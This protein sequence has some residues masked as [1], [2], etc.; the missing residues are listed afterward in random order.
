MKDLKLIALDVVDLGVLSAHL[1]DAVMLVGDMVYQPKQKRF[2]AI[3]NRFDW[4][5]ALGVTLEADRK[6]LRRHAALRFERVLKAQVSG[7]DLQAKRQALDLLAVRFEGKGAGPDGYATL[8]FAG[9]GQIR[10]QVECI[11]VELRDL[12][13]AWTA[14]HK[15]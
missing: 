1:Q 8:T 14:R 6:L 11:E 13:T 15:P 12:G 7:I 10:L 5:H 4:V 2:V 9:G 3:A